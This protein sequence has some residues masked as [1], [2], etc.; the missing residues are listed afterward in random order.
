MR[1]QCIH[2]TAHILFPIY[3]ILRFKCKPET[4]RVPARALA[5]NFS[6][7]CIHFNCVI[8]LIFESTVYCD[9][10]KQK[11]EQLIFSFLVGRGQNPAIKQINWITLSSVRRLLSDFR[12]NR[13]VNWI[14]E[15]KSNYN[16]IALNWH[17]INSAV[18]ICIL[19]NV[20]L[21]ISINSL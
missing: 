12:T 3:S 1:M 9:V 2:H 11:Y 16:I 4:N 17:S 18:W 14:E 8:I 19:V 10:S 13:T 20:W 7:F 5:Y 21:P 15:E 6:N